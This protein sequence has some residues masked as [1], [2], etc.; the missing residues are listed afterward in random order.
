V[1]SNGY[2]RTLPHLQ[3]DGGIDGFFISKIYKKF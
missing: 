3:I 1:T 2:I